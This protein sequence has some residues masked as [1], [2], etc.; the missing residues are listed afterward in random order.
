MVNLI[1]DLAQVC[2]SHQA[3]VRDLGF[4]AFGSSV[5]VQPRGE[6]GLTRETSTFED[7]PLSQRKKF[8]ADLKAKL[9][10]SIMEILSTSNAMLAS[11]LRS[12]NIY[13][14]ITVNTAGGKV[15]DVQVD[16]I[17]QKNILYFTTGQAFLHTE[18]F[19]EYWWSRKRPEILPV[20]HIGEDANW[21]RVG[22]DFVTVL[23]IKSNGTNKQYYGVPNA[24]AVL[25]CMLAEYRTLVLNSKIASTEL[26]SKLIMFFEEPPQERIR[27]LSA[28][29][30]Q[31]QFSQQIKALR[32]VATNEGETERNAAKAI[33]ALQ[34]PNDTNQPVVEPVT[35]NRD[36]AYAEFTLNNAASM[37]YAIHG[38]A[39]E[40]TGQVQVKTGIGANILYDIFSIK[41]VSTVIPLQ[42]KYENI[43]EWVITQCENL[44]ET[45]VGDYSIKFPDNIGQLTLQLSAVSQAAKIA[46]NLNKMGEQNKPVA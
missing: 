12:G 46:P 1:D 28:E 6:Q 26:V 18:Y 9:G 23:H 29:E 39:K 30:R 8:A 37:I 25:D 42:N 31:A 2:P 16:S 15:G 3:C 17:E 21:K 40:L 19:T 43:W 38:W 5:G 32:G 14:K 22:D 10:L 36:V 44:L 20:S 34:Y 4:Y 45:S 33:I 24:L 7:I 27:N 13:L 41:N 35:V 11:E